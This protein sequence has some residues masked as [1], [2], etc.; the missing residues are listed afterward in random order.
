VRIYHKF[1]VEKRLKRIL[2]F[3]FLK[4]WLWLLSEVRKTFVV[5]V[6]GISLA[7]PLFGNSNNSKIFPIKV[8]YFFEEIEE[9]WDNRTVRLVD[10]TDL[11][12]K[13]L[14]HLV[15]PTSISAMKTL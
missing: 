7:V 5:F 11:T 6:T 9:S 1:L 15:D 12:K 8:Q 4:L 2:I 14:H 10:T 3:T 13:S